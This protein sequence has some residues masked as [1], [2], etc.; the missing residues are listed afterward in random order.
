MCTIQD[1]AVR[2][3]LWCCSVCVILGIPA[4]LVVLRELFQRHRQGS[5]NNSFMLNLYT[6]DLIFTAMLPLAVCNVFVVKN[7]T[8]F[9]FISYVY[10]LPICGRPLL[11]ACICADCYFAVVYPL[12]YK[13]NKNVS[14]IRKAVTFV[15][16]CVIICYGALLYAVQSIFTS[17]LI[18][19]PLTIALP[20][21][22]FC[23]V[24]ILH[25][26]Q[27]PDPSGK[28]NIHRKK[29]QALYTIFSSLALTF[30]A[31]LPPAIIFTLADV[32]QLSQTTFFCNFSFIGLSFYTVGC[33]T[34]PLLHLNN[35]GKIVYFKWWL[36]KNVRT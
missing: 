28:K 16:W 27:K 22:T 21:I 29:R 18:S 3:W 10:C 36:M 15:V 12:M 7:I 23:D 26:L 9:Y 25:A 30:I 33:V 2:V 20:V 13:T 17:T 8:I 11:M 31:Y 5:C 19:A 32:L 1:L 34:M 24:S 4:C 6:I 35:L 14:V